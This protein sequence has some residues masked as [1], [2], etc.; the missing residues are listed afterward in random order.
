[1]A[2][3]KHIAGVAE[4]LEV[5]R[6]DKLISSF[7]PS[8]PA[9]INPKTGRLHTSL[10]ICGARTGRFSSR[11]PNLQQLPKKRSRAFRSVIVAREGKLL[12]AAD[13]SQIELRAGAEVI[14]AVVGESRLR[15]GFMV[16]IDAHRTTAMHLTGKND[17]QDVTEDE[18]DRAKA[19]NFGLLYGMSPLGFFFY[20]RDQY[21]PD[22]DEEEAYALYDAAHAAYPELNEWHYQW[23][24]QCRGDGYVETPL[25]RRWYWKWRARDEEK[26]DYDAGF[27]EDQRSGFRRNFAFNM[28]IQG[29][30][31]EVM[32]LAMAT[33]DRALR[34]YPARLC[35]TVHDEVLIELGD[36]PEI[37]AA[38]RD[39]VVTEMTAAFLHVFPDAPTI[40]LVAPKIGRSWG[41]QVSVEEWLSQPARP[42][43]TDSCACR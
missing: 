18:R 40:G 27:I 42:A 11:G 31:A 41:E 28:V 19:P 14:F 34:S 7:G 38:V 43:N 26:V 9:K 6:L 30:C 4:H 1:L 24:R 10:L 35:L 21:Q 20:V 22:I 33:L 36:A 37:I 39:V 15:D 12:M 8:L 25:R 32:L 2:Q 5:L 23:E 29:G 17:P 13:Y 16:G 3:A